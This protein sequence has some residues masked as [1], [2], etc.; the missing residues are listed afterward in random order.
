M[1]SS[2]QIIGRMILTH[3]NYE[4]NIQTIGR[5]ILVKWAM[6]YFEKDLPTVPPPGSN[7]HAPS[8]T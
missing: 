4:S 1:Y 5:M 3:T 8:H 7:E 2:I 6:L